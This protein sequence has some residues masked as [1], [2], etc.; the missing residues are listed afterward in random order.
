MNFQ[1]KNPFPEENGTL[2]NNCKTHSAV[3]RILFP[4]PPIHIEASILSMMLFGGGAFG[5]SLS[6]DET[7][8]RLVPQLKEE[9]TKSLSLMC[10]EHQEHERGSSAQSTKVNC[11]EDTSL[12]K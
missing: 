6:L 2:N 12:S 9:E 5:S 7:K 11:P 10:Q 3:D 8:R 4:L 1:E